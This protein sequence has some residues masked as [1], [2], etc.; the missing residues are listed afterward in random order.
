[1]QSGGR[2]R[3]HGSLFLEIIEAT[4]AELALVRKARREVAHL[5]AALAGLGGMGLGA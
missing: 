3:K 1:M 2:A 4:A 5:E